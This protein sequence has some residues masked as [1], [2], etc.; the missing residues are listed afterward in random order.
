MGDVKTRADSVHAFLSGA[1]SDGG[2]QADPNAALGN[3]RSSTRV[4]P[5][6]FL[7]QSPGIL[8]ELQVLRVAGE[9]S[10]GTG[11]IVRSA[12]D[13]LTYQAPGDTIGV[14]QKV[15]N[16]E[17]KVLESGTVSR[18][19]EVTRNGTLP[20][21]GTL[22]VKVVELL[23]GVIGFDDVF[24]AER[25]AG[26]DEYRALFLKNVSGS[27]IENLSIYL[28]ELAASQTTDAAQLPAGGAGTIGTVGTFDGWLN[29]GYSQ[30]RDLT[31]ALRE[32]VYY[33][34]RSSTVLTVPAAGRGLLGTVAGA[35][36]VTDTAHSAPGLRLGI[37]QPSAQPAG[38][39]QTIASEDTAP[40]AIAFSAPITDA[41][42]ISGGELDAGDILGVW[43]HRQAIAGMIASG[44]QLASLGF[45]FDAAT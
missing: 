11:S 9:S 14:A 21:I 42:G 19:V 33:S 29:Q 39:I 34:T 26:D 36:V 30:V 13:L 20:F 37:E 22:P 25:A 43:M 45:S 4:D 24:D 2:V 1:A 12:D 32:I 35:G 31:G 17:T 3:F 7:I 6:G 18:Y 8:P 40:A 28:L 5:A 16:G 38:F 27:D 10:E 44:R 41:S 15:L 23:N